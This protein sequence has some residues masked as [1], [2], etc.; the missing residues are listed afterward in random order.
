MAG[1]EVPLV[2]GGY[3][4]DLPL[5]ALINSSGLVEVAANQRSA[6]QLLAITGRGKEVGVMAD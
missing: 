3:G 2:T 4:Q 5:F 6:A 1:Q